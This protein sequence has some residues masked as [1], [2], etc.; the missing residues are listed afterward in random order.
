MILDQNVPF[1]HRP[2]HAT[3][4]TLATFHHADPARRAPECIGAGIDR[5]GQDVVHDVVGR[6]APH[7]A[8]RLASRD[9]AGNSMPSS[10]SQICT[11]RALWN[12]ANFVKTS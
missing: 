3:P 2:M 11:C 6:Q 10:L 12:S 4:D 5:I 8:V 9:L 7:D 1:V